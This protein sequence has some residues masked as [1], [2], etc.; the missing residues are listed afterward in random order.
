[1]S[2]TKTIVV[3]NRS[4]KRF[5]VSQDKTGGTYLEPGTSL[6]LPS[7]RAGKLIK[8]Y[9]KELVDMSKIAKPKSVS[10]IK[11]IKDRDEKIAALTAKITELEASLKEALTPG[12][13]ISVLQDK[14]ET[15]LKAAKKA[16]VENK[17]KK[18]DAALKAKVDEIEQDLEVEKNKE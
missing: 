18:K 10:N 12:V 2:E 6:E 15:A 9:P 4:K 1:M 16:V 5:K 8:M 13:P 14:L 7:E 17:D 3:Y 11:E